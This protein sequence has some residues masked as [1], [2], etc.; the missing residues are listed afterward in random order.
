MNT[1]K[2][3]LGNLEEIKRSEKFKYKKDLT[4][5]TLLKHDKQANLQKFHCDQCDSKFIEK[6]SLNAHKKMKHADNVLD[7]SSPVYGKIFKQKNTMKR[8]QPTNIYYVFTD[9]IF[10]INVTIK[11]LLM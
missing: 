4:V 9:L 1:S 5:H 6:K 8:H 11:L 3:M 10:K 2:A 7:F